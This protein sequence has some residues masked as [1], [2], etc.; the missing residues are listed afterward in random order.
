[1]HPNT[2]RAYIQTLN[3]AH[4]IGFTS[5][6]VHKFDDVFTGGSIRDENKLLLH[7]DC[8]TAKKPPSQYGQGVSSG[9]HPVHFASRPGAIRC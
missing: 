5:F 8:T 4:A 6:E 9:M 2:S 3:E 1:M 7:G